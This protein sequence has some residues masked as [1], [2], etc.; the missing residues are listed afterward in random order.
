MFVLVASCRGA[1]QTTGYTYTS[2]EGVPRRFRPSCC[3]DGSTMAVAVVRQRRGSTAV[4]AR[5]P[6]LGDS[7]SDAEEDARPAVAPPAAAAPFLD[8]DEDDEDDESGRPVELRRYVRSLSERSLGYLST[9]SSDKFIYQ[10]LEFPQPPEPPEPERPQ[11]AASLLREA[12]SFSDIRL[13]TSEIRSQTSSQPNLH[14]STS[15]DKLAFH[16]PFDT[17]MV[18]SFSQVP[19][20]TVNEAA[21]QVSALGPGAYGGGTVAPRN[22]SAGARLVSRRPASTKH[23]VEAAALGPGRYTPGLSGL[24]RAIG[25][26]DE[27]MPSTFVGS[28]SGYDVSHKIKEVAPDCGTYEPGVMPGIVKAPGKR[29]L[30]FGKPNGQGNAAVSSSLAAAMGSTPPAVGPGKYNPTIIAT[31]SA[32]KAFLVGRPTDPVNTSGNLGPGA[33]QVPDRPPVT[34]PVGKVGVQYSFASRPYMEP[35]LPPEEKMSVLV[36]SKTTES[37]VRHQLTEAGRRER[38]HQ[39]S[40]SFLVRDERI[41]KAAV[42]KAARDVE[43]ESQRRAIENKLEVRAEMRAKRFAS[44]HRQL[45][46]ATIVKHGAAI[47]L[48]SQKVSHVRKQVEEEKRASWAATLIATFWRRSMAL[49]KV[50]QHRQVV[51]AHRLIRDGLGRYLARARE[52]AKHHSQKV[53]VNF[54][55]EVRDSGR[56]PRAVRTAVFRIRQVQRAWRRYRARKA[57]YLE[58]AMMQWDWFEPRRVLIGEKKKKKAESGISTSGSVKFDLAGSSG[59]PEPGIERRSSIASVMSADATPPVQRPKAL[60]RRDSVKSDGASEDESTPRRKLKRRDSTKSSSPELMT[61]RNGS[62]TPRETPREASGSMTPRSMT[63]RSGGATPRGRKGKDKFAAT[64]LRAHPMRGQVQGQCVLAE[65]IKRLKLRIWLKERQRAHRKEWRQYEAKIAEVK[66]ELRKESEGKEI[67]NEAKNLLGLQ[68]N[69]LSSEQE[70]KRRLHKLAGPS[71]IRSPWLP[72]RE[73]NA[74]IDEALAAHHFK[75][76][77]KR[78]KSNSHVNLIEPT[79]TRTPSSGAVIDTHIKGD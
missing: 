14:N 43:I 25:E 32:P 59:K 42:V 33:H 77:T 27:T 28:S 26:Y 51:L 12:M 61:P 10:H 40:M 2:S 45:F 3:A 50:R 54:F 17:K 34:N 41:A 8:E 4:R 75:P 44:L 21:L 16:S 76:E 5:S 74:L 24:R 22:S 13:H 55:E 46:F 69:K 78:K 56:L 7:A 30:E 68:L 58:M 9:L 63:P 1:P 39:Q 53:L 70:F 29:G 52:K 19:R 62:M 20:W 79:P 48:L 36:R 66:E 6:S 60:K 31:K 64:G 67:I 47:S 73:L 71:P 23:L 15:S 18:H 35:V 57:A 11:S 72:E 49:A 37:L 65:P 38:K